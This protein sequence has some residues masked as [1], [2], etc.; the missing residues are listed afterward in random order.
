MQLGRL[1]AGTFA[2]GRDAVAE[3]E[4]ASL[5]VTQ[6]SSASPADRL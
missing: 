2:E 1:L 4:G 5:K 3:A 6:C